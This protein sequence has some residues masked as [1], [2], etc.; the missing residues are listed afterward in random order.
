MKERFVAIGL[1][2]PDNAAYTAM[3]T[4]QRLGVDVDRV[5]RSEIWQLED[6]LEDS[7]IARRV[8]RN[9]TIF[10]PNK[11]TSKE[12]DEK[13][14]GCH[15]GQ[16]QNFERSTHAKSGVG[17]TSCHSVHQKN[18]T[19][20]LLKASQPQLCYQC[21]ADQRPAFS[22]LFHHKV[23]EGAVSCTDCHDAHGTFQRSNLRTTADKNAI[24]TKCHTE[25]RGPFVFE[26]AA[27]KAEGC[28]GCH[29]PHGSQ[30]PRL[31][32]MPNIVEL[33]RSCHSAVATGTVHGMGEGSETATPCIS[34]H[35]M[36][37]G[38][39]VSQAFIR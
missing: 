25:T 16:H 8:E 19:E 4:L 14:L 38:S 9:E 6:S 39:N 18:E 27:V 7:T 32:N 34:C 36:I 11:H 3:V 13:C 29:T 12:V 26:H 21:H 15:A 35:T 2:I 10:N 17:C 30:N 37:H 23:N 24:C 33:C 22:M 28:V 31:L 1:K 20:H 5:E